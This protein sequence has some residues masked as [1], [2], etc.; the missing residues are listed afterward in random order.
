L[1]NNRI[2]KYLAFS[3]LVYGGLLGG[4]LL[5]DHLSK[6]YSVTYEGIFWVFGVMILTPLFIGLLLGLEK[7][8]SSKQKGLWKINWYRLIILGIPALMIIVNFVLSFLGIANLMYKLSKWTILIKPELIMPISLI[9]GYVF[10]SSFFRENHGIPQ[11][12]NESHVP[13]TL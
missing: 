13:D 2:I 6:M 3:L 12:K 10:G 4:E 7:S 9:L 11:S 5:L 1:K 8:L